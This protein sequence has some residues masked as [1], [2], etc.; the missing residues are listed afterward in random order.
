V[1][2][3]MISQCEN[4][5]WLPARLFQMHVIRIALAYA[6]ITSFHISPRRL[7]TLSLDARATAFPINE[8]EETAQNRKAD[9]EAGNDA[10]NYLV[11]A[12]IF[13]VIVRLCVGV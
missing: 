12:S 3:I 10:S 2:K 6:R 9:E 4:V 7:L 5:P 1:P 8:E 13:V 11:Y